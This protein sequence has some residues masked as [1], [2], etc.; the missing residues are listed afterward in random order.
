MGRV[1]RP[2]KNTPT[3][4][5]Q[6]A[7]IVR[8]E[9][10]LTSEDIA[11]K[12]S[13]DETN[14]VSSRLIRKS[15]NE[16][17]YRSKKPRNVP[18]LT[19]K[20]IEARLNWAKSHVNMDWSRVFFSDES[21]V[22]LCSNMVKLWTKNSKQ[23]ENPQNKDRTKVMFWGGFSLNEKSQLEFIDGRMTGTVY[24]GILEKHILPLQLRNRRGTRTRAKGIIF[25]HDNDPKHTCKLVKNY[26]QEK[27][28][29]VLEW[30]SCSPDLNP[31]ENLWAIIKAKVA[32]RFPKNKR[33]LI[34]FLIEE[35]NKI[36]RSTIENLIKSMKKRCE[37]LIQNG[38]KRINY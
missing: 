21:F 29:E 3:L 23:R 19:K 8:H 33:E 35:W 9:P 2:P 31:I 5:K 22:Q 6:I 20:Y 10:S 37:E 32:K 7:Q 38:G 11:R 12:V 13:I 14:P 15:L 25:Q 26:I 18:M 1:G 36:D 16:M 4:R 30:P 17:E 28:I 24:R 34:E 27:G